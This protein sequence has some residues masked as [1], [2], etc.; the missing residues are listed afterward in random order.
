MASPVRR[1][2]RSC[3]SSLPAWSKPREDGC[4]LS[5]HSLCSSGS[6]V[7]CGNGATMKHSMLAM[8]AVVL[9]C[10]GKTLRT[11]SVHRAAADVCGSRPVFSDAAATTDADCVA[12]ATCACVSDLQCVPQNAF[13]TE[14]RCGQV[15]RGAG[16][17]LD[18]CPSTCERCTY[19]TCHA[20]SDCVSTAA[21]GLG[22]C[23]CRETPDH[24]LDNASHANPNYCVYGNN[25]RV[26][27]DCKTG[28][29]YCSPSADPNCGNFAGYFCHTSDDECVDNSD[30]SSGVC[31]WM[32]TA[33]HWLC[34]SPQACLDGGV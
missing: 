33:K 25:C 29:P 4:E 26:D 16:Q 23:D 15:I 17:G 20:D 3:R 32:A 22:I 34:V 28:L 31:A 19:D 21:S 5:V 11:P 2:T 13:Q 7:A 30:C 12:A 6:V 27:T 10:N 18:S 9:G 14:G 1:R 8:A 24:G